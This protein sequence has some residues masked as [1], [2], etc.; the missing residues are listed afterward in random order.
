MDF[1][2]RHVSRPRVIPTAFLGHSVHGNVHFAG[3]H[4]RRRGVTFGSEIQGNIS[5]GAQPNQRYRASMCKFL[6][7][8]CSRCYV[9]RDL[10]RRRQ[11]SAYSNALPISSR[12]RGCQICGYRRTSCPSTELHPNGAVALESEA[13]VVRVGLTS[14]IQYVTGVNIVPDDTAEGQTARPNN[15][16]G[17][18]RSPL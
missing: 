16:R 3:E 1:Q 7:S 14:V 11:I 12:P 6:G 15:C 9:P 17:R 2:T 8:F 4:F 18:E 5:P 13:G 10:E